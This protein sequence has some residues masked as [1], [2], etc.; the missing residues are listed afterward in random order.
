[1]LFLGIISW[2]KGV[3]HFNGGGFVFQMGG[4]FLSG[5]SAPL[6]YGGVSKK[7]MPPTMGNPEKYSIFY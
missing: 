1:M 4:S 6:F 7:M 3:S 2:K 5:G